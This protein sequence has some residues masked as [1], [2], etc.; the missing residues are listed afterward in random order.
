MMPGPSTKTSS[1][2]AASRH[3]EMMR[4]LANRVLPIC[5]SMPMIHSK[6]MHP[7]KIYASTHPVSFFVSFVR[8]AYLSVRLVW[9]PAHIVTFGVITNRLAYLRIPFATAVSFA[10]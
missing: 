8:C 6:D 5:P 7:L 3:G 9:I 1:G 2:R 4:I 10:W